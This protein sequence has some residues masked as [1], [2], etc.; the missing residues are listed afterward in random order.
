MQSTFHEQF[1]R[2]EEFISKAMCQNEIYPNHNVYHLRV[3]SL[4]RMI[5]KGSWDHKR[6]NVQSSF[7]LVHAV[8]DT[9]NTLPSKLGVRLSEKECIG[10]KEEIEGPMVSRFN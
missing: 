1:V 10:I 2:E 3:Q 7:S 9:A 8:R 5:L 4:G 6:K